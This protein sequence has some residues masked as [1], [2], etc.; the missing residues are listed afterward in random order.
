MGAVKAPLV[1][2]RSAEEEERPYYRLID[3]CHIL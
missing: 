3:G 1:V 2:L